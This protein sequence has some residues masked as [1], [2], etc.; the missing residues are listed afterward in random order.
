MKQVYFAHGKE[1]GPWGSKIRHLAS[2]AEANGYEVVSPDY[3]ALPDPEARVKHLLGL[4]SQEP[5]TSDIVLVGSS[6]GGYISTVVASSLPIKGLFLMAPALYIPSYSVQAYAP[7]SD[8]VYVVHGEHD[9]VIPLAHSQ[10]FAKETTCTLQ[11][12]DGDH[13][14]NSVLRELGCCFD[15]FLQKMAG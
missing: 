2:I 5:E 1:S 11:V 14:L 13:R 9:E 3:Y 10:R 12:L 8:H 15:E 4:L 7:Q 6:M